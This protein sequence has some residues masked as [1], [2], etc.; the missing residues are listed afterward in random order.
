M[1]WIK[2]LQFSAFFIIYKIYK[3]TQIA[4]KYSCGECILPKL[5]N[6]VRRTL[7]AAFS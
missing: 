1:V 5:K 3:H 6:G 4:I 2:K 7:F